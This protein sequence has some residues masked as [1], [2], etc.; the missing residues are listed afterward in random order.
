MTKIKLLVVSSLVFMLCS[1]L[2]AQNYFLWSTDDTDTKNDEAWNNSWVGQW[3]GATIDHGP[4]WTIPTETNIIHSGTTSIKFKFHYVIGGGALGAIT[5]DP[6]NDGTPPDDAVEQNSPKNVRKFSTLSFW[7]KGSNQSDAQIEF[8]DTDG[9]ASVR[10]NLTNFVKVKTNWQH[11]YIATNQ[12]DWWGCDRSKLK[13]IQFVVEDSNYNNWAIKVPSHINPGDFTF[14]IDDMIF[15]NKPVIPL[16]LAAIGISTNEISLS[17]ITNGNNTSYTLFRRD[18]NNT[19]AMATKIGFSASQSSYVD[20]PVAT[21]T[22]YYYW[23]KSYNILDQSAY[24]AVSCATSLSPSSLPTVPVM[25]SSIAM[26]TNTIYMSWQK[27]GFVTSYTL[28]RNTA[29]STNSGLVKYG[30][31]AAATNYMNNNLVKGTTNYYW[32]KAYNKNGGTAY[33]TGKFAVTGPPGAPI[34][35][36]VVSL[37]TNSIGIIWQ[38]SSF[39]T[40]Y[41]LFRNLNENTNAFS[42]TKFGFSASMTN[43]TDTG[44]MNGTTYYY[45]VKAY[46]LLGES[47]Y[48]TGQ[49]ATT[50]KVEKKAVTGVKIY[51]NLLTGNIKTMRIVF[52]TK[53]SGNAKITICNEFGES[54]WSKSIPCD[55]GIQRV[56]WSRPSKIGNGI[57]IV[58]INFESSIQSSKFIIKK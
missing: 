34:I 43:Y 12:I 26:S 37:N 14:Y 20:T 31:N 28:F 15:G 7:I 9:D 44:L 41:T 27:S 57:Y 48:S 11:V 4:A 6:N 47:G 21:N 53:E 54:I 8:G 56:E 13:Y 49:S 1:V 2:S 45:W 38:K 17:W 39:V 25:L 32:M 55:I 29:N 10:I 36:S 5:S 35:L 24:S 30:F 42:M 18:S 33:S 40:A 58:Y 46:N 52:E 50:I 3:N 22:S 51:P 16:N 23:I 19:D